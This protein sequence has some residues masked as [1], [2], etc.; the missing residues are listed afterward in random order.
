M[1]VP[2]MNFMTSPALTIVL[3]CRFVECSNKGRRYLLLDWPVCLFS[4]QRFQT[5][6]SLCE[7][8]SER[9]KMLYCS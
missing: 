1:R 9:L 8:A 3:L 4:S 7:V 6:G 5:H 2:C